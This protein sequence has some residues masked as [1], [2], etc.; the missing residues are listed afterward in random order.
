[1]SPKLVKI[2]LVVSLILLD[3]GCQKPPAIE[4]TSNA[5]G[6]YSHSIVIGSAALSVDIVDDDAERSQGLS[7]RSSMDENQGMLF[8]FKNA[9]DLRRPGF[10]MKGM[11]FDLDLIWVRDNQIVEITENV[12]HVKGDMANA[13]NLPIYYPSEKVD[14]VIEVNAGWGERHDIKLG[15]LVQL[16]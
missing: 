13:N 2:L 4:Q 6:S 5:S 7:G 11:Q 12:P 16:K 10:W 15:D 8:D 14:T 3:V 9:D 1:M